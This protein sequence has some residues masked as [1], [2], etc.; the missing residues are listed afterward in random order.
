MRETMLIFHF[1]GLSMGLGS[2]FAYMFLGFVSS[3]MSKGERKAFFVNVS[4]IS[5]MANIGLIILLISGLYLITPFWK[6]L[7]GQPFLIAKLILVLI[8][9]GLVLAIN[10]LMKKSKTANIDLYAGKIE[11]LGKVIMLT[12]L[13]ILILAVTIFH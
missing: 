6:V 4:I 8:L 1:I 13:I 12:T 11:T 9:I 3:K 5:K 10:S 7:G 2:S